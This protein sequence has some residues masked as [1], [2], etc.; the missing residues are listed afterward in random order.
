MF[1]EFE[2]FCDTV[3]QRRCLASLRRV[4]SNFVCYKSTALTLG[5]PALLWPSLFLGDLRAP[6]AGE[7]GFPAGWRLV[8][9]CGGQ[10]VGVWR[11]AVC[12]SV[13]L[14]VVLVCGLWFL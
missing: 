4:V 6:G 11:L 10:H 1:I 3:I 2:D 14:M 7:L 8:V 9:L 12:L 5:F 13:D